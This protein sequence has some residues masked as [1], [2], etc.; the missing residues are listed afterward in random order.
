MSHYI[1]V[2]NLRYT[3]SLQSSYL[4]A[5]GDYFYYDSSKQP[6]RFP[7]EKAVRLCVLVFKW[8]MLFVA[9][10]ISCLSN[11]HLPFVLIKKPNFAQSVNVPREI[12]LTFIQ[13]PLHVGVCM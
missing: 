4:S 6:Q 10:V 3:V 12:I 9:D 8:R 13:T 11:S 7:V 5:L 2:A 1:H